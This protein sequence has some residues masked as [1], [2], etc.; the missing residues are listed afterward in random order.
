MQS[1]PLTRSRRFLVLLPLLLVAGMPLLLADWQGQPTLPA[2]VEYEHLRRQD[3]LLSIHVLKIAREGGDFRWASTLARGEIFGLSPVSRQVEE[4]RGG[5][6]EPVAAVNADFFRIAPG[7]YQGDMLGL[8]IS[9]GELISSPSSASFWL[10]PAGQPRIGAA[11]TRIGTTMISADGS[12]RSL[13]IGLNGPRTD[14]RAVLFTPALG[15][16]TRAEGGLELTLMGPAGAP[17]PLLRP[18][19]SFLASVTSIHDGG[20]NPIP[21]GGM[22][23]SIG[24]KLAAELQ[25]PSVGMTLPID[26]ETTPSLAGVTTAVGGGPIL[27]IEGRVAAGADQ[28]V[29]HPRTAVG[30]SDTHI[31]LVAVDGRQS[32]LSVGM[33]MPELAELMLELGATEAINLDGGGSTTMWVAGQVVNSPSDGRERSVANALVLLRRVDP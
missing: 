20:N 22:V 19:A 15:P 23:L 10:D 8:K 32:M 11:R 7:P 33:S 3:P 25:T 27:L 28:P 17:L 9:E 2:G 1:L 24:P 26:V 21:D 6:W 12:E 29:R 30:F 4:L 5:G 16:T 13:T 14:D 18:D 31:F